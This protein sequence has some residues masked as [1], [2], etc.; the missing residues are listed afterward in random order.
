ML[1]LATASTITGA[2]LGLRFRVFILAPA[3][4]LAAILSI[5]AA[6]M[7]FATP[8]GA[9]L[10]LAVTVVGLQLGFLCG[11][12]LRQ[13]LTGGSRVTNSSPEPRGILTD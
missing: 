8:T 3:M 12:V 1:I 5:L 13:L 4:A 7:E 10:A 9:L 2:L 6:V 11:T